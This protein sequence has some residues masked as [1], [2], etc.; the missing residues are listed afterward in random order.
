MALNSPFAL[1]LAAVLVVAVGL[2]ALLLLRRRGAA[3][4]VESAVEAPVDERPLAERTAPPPVAPEPEPR[5]ETET[6]PEPEPVPG[7]EEPAVVR[8]AVPEAVRDLP[9][10]EE[11]PEWFV[12]F[13]TGAPLEPEKRSR[14]R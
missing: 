8:A 7:L 9:R 3:A 11:L 6:E 13:R 1:I 2:L 14:R 4:E 5:P 10:A 12:R